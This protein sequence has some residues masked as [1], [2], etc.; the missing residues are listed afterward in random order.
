VH[1]LFKVATKYRGK[2]PHAFVVL[3][4]EGSRWLE[5]CGGTLTP[6]VYVEELDRIAEGIALGK[7][8]CPENHQVG[9]AV[10]EYGPKIE[11]LRGR[12]PGIP[13]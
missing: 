6:Q 10:D 4:R 11:E 5:K 2:A 13:V 9:Y 7:K 8:Y 3:A 12:G 1:D